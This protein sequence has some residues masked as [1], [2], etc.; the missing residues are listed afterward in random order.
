[1]TIES[2]S[3]D[4]LN[5]V[6]GGAPNLG[7]YSYNGHGLVVPQSEG[8]SWGDIYKAWAQRGKD[9]AAGKTQF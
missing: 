5:A 4:Q 1:M 3:D 9:L 6:S 2:L 7:G 8:P